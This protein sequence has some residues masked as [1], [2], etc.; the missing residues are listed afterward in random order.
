[1]KLTSKYLKKLILEAFVE[2]RGKFL[3]WHAFGWGGQSAGRL[4]KMDPE[5]MNKTGVKLRA[6]MI[7]E[8][9]FTP[10]NGAMY[11]KGVYTV[12]DPRDISYNKYGP[13]ALQF[14]IS[15]SAVD[16]SFLVIPSNHDDNQIE[17]YK[18]SATTIE[19]QLEAFGVLN[20]ETRELIKKHS[21]EYF[22]S[23]LALELSRLKYVRDAIKGLIFHGAQDGH[24]LV[25]YDPSLLKLT[26]YTSSRNSQPRY[27]TEIEFRF[28]KNPEEI[29]KIVKQYFDFPNSRSTDEE[30]QTCQY[31]DRF[32]YDN[33]YSKEAMLD[34]ARNGL[35]AEE[36]RTLKTY[37][38]E[39]TELLPNYDIPTQED[40]D[41]HEKLLDKL[42]NGGLT[43]DERWELI[44][45]ETI[46]DIPVQ[47]Y[48]ARTWADFV[49]FIEGGAFERMISGLDGSKKLFGI[50]KI[51]Q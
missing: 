31:V 1:M 48:K 9:G 19:E 15:K 6:R 17:D 20:E 4:G 32:M 41:D 16:Q 28:N 7:K 45:L 33:K 47:Q 27:T 13:L 3:C 44:E 24:V 35:R 29:H 8:K 37:I 34:H 12:M 11:G 49:Q 46:I 25:C 50:K 39:D 36:L 2:K 23:G 26:G 43:P 10:G 42:M 22:G 38:P 51:K 5:L 21:D 14:E 40:Y 30:I 18:S